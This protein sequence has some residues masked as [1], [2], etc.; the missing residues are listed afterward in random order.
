MPGVAVS[1]GAVGQ[2]RK[3]IGTMTEIEIHLPMRIAV[4]QARGVRVSGDSTAYNALTAC[5]QKYFDAYARHGQDSP[6]DVPGVQVARDLFRA[7]RVDPTKTRPS[8]EA[9]L[10]R[11]LKG[12]SL[13]KINSLVDVGNWCSLDF[14]LPLGLYDGEKIEGT[15]VIRVGG[16]GEKYDG[17]GNRTINV[18]GRYVL[19]DDLGPFGS[20]VADSLRTAITE[21]TRQALMILLA[22]ANYDR[23][24]LSNHA[25]TAARRIRDI[26]GGSTEDIRIIS[27]PD[28]TAGEE[29]C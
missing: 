20:P 18:D 10:R 25:E 29:G 7:V 22:P 28:P 6:G 16:S 21:S 13:Y 27:G 26:C 1:T 11:A 8:S 14:L 15:I 4:I 24:Q 2:N 23:E 19:G 17:I 12:K 5:A 9:L 3:T